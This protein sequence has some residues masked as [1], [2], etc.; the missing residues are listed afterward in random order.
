MARSALASKQ[1]IGQGPIP[2]AAYV[3]PASVFV[4]ILLACLPIVA[5]SGW[6]PDFGFLILIAWRLL[7]ADVWP[8]WWAAPLGLVNDLVGGYPV[9]LSMAV[10][11]VS[12]LALDLIDRRTIWRD[13]WI[14]WA[15]AI[16]LILFNE[17]AQWQIAAWMGAPVPYSEMIPPLLISIAAFP[18]AA[19]IVGRLDRWRL[20]RQ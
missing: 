15:L 5:L 10:W 4:A 11:T 17:T 13:Y 19:W 3:P 1:K 7:R 18:I 8:S 12:M 14:E 6:F 9:G 16:L 20:G 2:G